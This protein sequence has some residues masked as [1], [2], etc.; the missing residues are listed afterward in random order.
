LTL[1]RHVPPVFDRNRPYILS[2]YFYVKKNPQ[3]A[4]VRPSGDMN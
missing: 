4:F 1:L 3:K 2:K